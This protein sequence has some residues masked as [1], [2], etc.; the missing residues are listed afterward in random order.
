VGPYDGERIHAFLA[1][2]RTGKP[3]PTPTDPEPYPE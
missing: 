2:A 3:L 1:A